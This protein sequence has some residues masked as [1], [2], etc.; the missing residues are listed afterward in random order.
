MD[1]G[2]ATTSSTYMR[3]YYQPTCTECDGNA[4]GID[5]AA[6]EQH[7]FIGDRLTN[8]TAGTVATQGRAGVDLAVLVTFDVTGTEEVD[9][10]GKYFDAQPP[11]P[12]YIE[13]LYLS[14]S[15][16]SWTVVDMDAASA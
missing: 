15:G 11:T 2:Y 4:T 7:R 8:I 6:Q 16:V 9:K 14:W 1:W 5:E 12:G 13:T 10:S 3:H